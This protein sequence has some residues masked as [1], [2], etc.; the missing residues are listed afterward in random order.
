MARNTNIDEILF[1]VELK[2]V[3]VTGTNKSIKGF[4][5]VV[6]NLNYQDSLFPDEHVFSIVTDD[7]V[8]I[9]NQTALDMAKD[10]HKRLFPGGSTDSFVIFNIKTPGTL[11]SC[12]I[13]I[14]DKNYKLNILEKEVYVPFVRIQNSYNKTMPLC[15]QVGFCRKLCNNGVI[16]E[17]NT[18]SIN[19]RHTK[20]HFSNF[21][22][23]H[24]D[25]SW[26]KQYE[27]DFTS[28]IEKSTK[29]KIP[30]DKFVPLAA[31]AL[32][33]KF[34]LENKKSKNYQIN[35]ERLE[36]FISRIEDYSDRYIRVEKLGETA[37][38]FFNV[39]TGFASNVDHI[40]AR[41][42][43]SMQGR[44]GGWLSE[45]CKEYSGKKIDWDKELDGS[46]I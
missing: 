36:D 9:S 41:T 31:K 7:Y 16:F 45:F 38:A 14:I 24:I 8:L 22:L 1:P 5:A 42:T 25:T 26:L 11:G 6:G 44:C 17:Q 35:L 40:Q 27:N 19:L 10:I 2:P 30:K 46:M 37:Y 23:N 33:L 28:K 29:I 39:I 34:D 15:F 18:I 12:H 13:D 3:M 21:S 32:N 43:H 4:K 20:S